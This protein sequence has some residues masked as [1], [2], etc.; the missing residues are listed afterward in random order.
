MSLHV[1]QELSLPPRTDEPALEP[2]SLT[3]DTEAWTF[4]PP[5]DAPPETCGVAAPAHVQRTFSASVALFRIA[6]RVVD[7]T[8]LRR[9]PDPARVMEVQYAFQ[10]AHACL[11]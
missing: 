8:G 2:E 11:C 4:P 6:A 5:A 3:A 7:I 10:S 1:G 9:P